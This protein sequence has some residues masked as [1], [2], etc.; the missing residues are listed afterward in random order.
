MFISL[1]Q[2]HNKLSHLIQIILVG[3]NFYLSVAFLLGEIKETGGN[4]PVLLGDHMSISHAELVEQGNYWY[5]FYNVF[6]MT[7]SLT[8]EWTRDLPHLKPALY[9]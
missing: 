6:G 2:L 3:S 9:H 4:S 8:R 7:R 5:H 1:Q